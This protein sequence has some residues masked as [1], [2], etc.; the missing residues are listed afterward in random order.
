[1]LNLLETLKLATSVAQASQIPPRNAADFQTS[2]MQWRN[3]PEFAHSDHRNVATF[4]HS[5]FSSQETTEA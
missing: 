4:Y 1:M 5:L 3:P 2:N